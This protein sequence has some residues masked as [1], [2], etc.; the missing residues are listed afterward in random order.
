MYPLAGV[1]SREDFYFILDRQRDMLKLH[2]LFTFQCARGLGLF[3]FQC[4]RGPGQ[5]VCP[6]AQGPGQHVCPRDA[7]VPEGLGN[8]PEQ[9]VAREWGSIWSNFVP[10][11][12]SARVPE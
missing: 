4:A 1:T 5:H 11:C 6:S 8:I 12:P 7:C 10:E 9:H 3:T 2:G